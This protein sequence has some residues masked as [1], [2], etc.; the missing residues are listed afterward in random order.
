VRGTGFIAV[1]DNGGEGIERV[2]C[3]QHHPAFKDAPSVD[4]LLAHTSETRRAL[5]ASFSIA[6]LTV[7]EQF[8][9]YLEAYIKTQSGIESSWNDE[10]DSFTH[11][12][13]PR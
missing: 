8:L 1:A 9:P 12:G 5:A 10:D 11:E 3:G 4:E 2:E 6:K 13:E 7:S